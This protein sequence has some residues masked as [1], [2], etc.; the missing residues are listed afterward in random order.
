MGELMA[1]VSL[2]GVLPAK[3]R[4]HAHAFLDGWIRVWKIFV[5]TCYCFAEMIWLVVVG[6]M[7]D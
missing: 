3:E 6:V 2:R 1:K 4:G 5:R 7:D